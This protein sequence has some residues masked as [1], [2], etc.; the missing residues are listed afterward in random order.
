[1][2]FPASRVSGRTSC[3]GW[4]TALLLA[5]APAASRGESL[6]DG[7]TFAGW[8]GDT[9]AVWRID[10]GAIV[11]GQ[12]D[13]A[14]PRN[15][16]LATDRRF[17][18]FELRL[19]Y[20]LDC[21]ADCNA[22]IQFRTV[23]I[24]NHHEVI[25]YQ[26]DIGPGFEGGL[27]DESRRNRMLVN[28]EAATVAA[29]LAKARDGWNEYVVRC[30]GPRIRLAINGVE[31]ADYTEPDP[32][33]AREGVIALQIHGK[34]RGTI[35]YRNIR[36]T[37]FP[38]LL[39][40]DFRL[41]AAGEGWQGSQAPEAF[42][43]ETVRL[44]GDPDAHG[45]R[46]VKGILTSPPI[47]VEP[48][49]FYRLRAL[50]RGTEGGHCAVSFLDADGHEIVADDYDSIDATP[51]WQPYELCFRGHADARQAR[52]H[53]RRN[54]N[55][56][57]SAPLEVK[58]VRVE[59]I[60]APVAAAWAASLAA[61]CPTVSFEPPADRWRHLPTS[62]AKLAAGER[63]R[64]VMLGDSICNDTSNSLY[65]TLLAARY[66]GARI[67]VVT[68][69]RGGTGCWY[70]KDESRVQSYVLD[71][72]PDLVI[73]AG[74]SHGFDV[75][76]I[77]SVVRQI[78]AGSDCEILVMTGAVAPRDVIEPAFATGRPPDVALDMMERFP[79]AL[80][81]M[82]RE[83]DVEF[84]DMRRT[85]DDYVRQ[86]YKPSEHF[87]RDSIHANSRGKAVLGRILGL[88][89]GPKES[90]NAGGSP[91]TSSVAPAQ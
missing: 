69:V 55:R 62:L 17:G 46:I 2:N 14:A 4:L 41:S 85:W 12:P 20:R 76:S 21:V 27:Y 51:S 72:H 29:A 90:P 83:E 74:I 89:F 40:T 5:A 70:Y 24:P 6:F 42:V 50:V 91:L 25:G 48:F 77:R 73:I 26:A 86:S 67:E 9:A 71:K 45:V 19:E 68:S 75:E 44:A 56:S 53:L 28:P 23:R 13:K 52:V 81:A 60:T 43:G 79:G 39:R 31:T 54:Y 36:I 18:D 87:A 47:A 78:R 32:S 64:I 11:A 37:E 30:E 10:D 1:M 7:A 15:E 33:I 57:D 88:Y 59:T 66:P 16:F 22:G 49:A 84:F 34:M 63:L 3:S 82:C 58:N 8:N 35:R 61:A 80:A 38:P 65:E